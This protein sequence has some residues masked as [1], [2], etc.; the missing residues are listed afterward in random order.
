MPARA[1]AVP[2][3]GIHLIWWPMP[4]QVLLGKVYVL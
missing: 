3:R 2:V 1:V 4:Q